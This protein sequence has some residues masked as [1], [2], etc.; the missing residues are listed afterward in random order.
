MPAI[1]NPKELKF[2]HNLNSLEIFDLLTLSPR[3]SK[4]VNSKHL[5]FDI[6]KLEPGKFSFPYHFHLNAEELMLV[7]SGELTLRT[8]QGFEIVKQGQLMFFEIG[9]SGVH[10]FYNHKNRPCVYLDIRTNMGIDVTE[11]PDSG[12]VNILPAQH[13]YEKSTQVSYNKGEDN[14]KEIWDEY[15]RRKTNNQ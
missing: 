2:Q 10:Q 3:L 5:I 8:N 11:Y 4:I 15:F 13:V 14:I 6:R 9:E 7:I 12:K 1:I